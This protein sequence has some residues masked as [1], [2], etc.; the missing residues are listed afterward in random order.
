MARK[1]GVEPSV[2]IGVVS[3]ILEQA[4][5]AIGRGS[6]CELE[7]APLGT[8][9]MRPGSVRL[10]Q[11][12]PPAVRPTAPPG[13]KPEPRPATHAVLTGGKAGECEI[14]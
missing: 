10:A 4:G 9:E 1:L 11:A 8:L 12:K 6:S 14:Y 5:K 13:E 7:V 3:D 2:V